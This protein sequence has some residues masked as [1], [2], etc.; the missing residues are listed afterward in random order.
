[1]VNTLGWVG[2]KGGIAKMRVYED[3]YVLCKSHL[4]CVGV[5]GYN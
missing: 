5:C 4:L 1:M 2:R 3:S